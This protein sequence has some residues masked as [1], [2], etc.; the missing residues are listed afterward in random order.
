MATFGSDWEDTSEK[1]YEG[2]INYAHS[3]SEAD[4]DSFGEEYKGIMGGTFSGGKRAL[5]KAI[6]RDLENNFTSNL[7]RKKLL[8]LQE[9]M[10]NKY[11]LGGGLEPA[12]I[13]QHVSNWSEIPSSW[14]KLGAFK[15]IAFTSDPYDKNL[16]KLL[17]PFASDDDLRPAMTGM[18]F[19]EAGITC[20]DAHK[21]VVLPYPN[22]EYKGIYCTFKRCSKL[23]SGD[24]KIDKSGKLIEKL[25]K[26]T[27][28]AKY[29]KYEAVIPIC[30]A[31]KQNHDKINLRKLLTYI[32]VAENF[33]NVT[34]HQIN[35]K[36]KG[37][38]I[39]F[40]STFLKT[41]CEAMLYLGYEDVWFHTST[42]DR[43]VVVTPSETYKLGVEV[44]MLC[45][46]VHTDSKVYSD[47]PGAE[48]MD[49]EKEISV[50]FDFSDNEI[51]NADKT[52]ADFYK[53][54]KVITIQPEQIRFLKSAIDKN[55][56]IPILDH[57]GV[58]S[59]NAIGADFENYAI[60]KESGL[61]DGEYD[62]VEGE[63]VWHSGANDIN[64]FPKVYTAKEELGKVYAPEFEKVYE[65]AIKF[66]IKDDFAPEFGGIHLYTK[67][68][69]LVMES[70]DA[71]IAY[72]NIIKGFE[73]KKNLILCCQLNA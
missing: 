6:E 3:E 9:K 43:A 67:D 64:E 1:D 18:Y 54:E 5:E 62:I 31:K 13:T 48:D 50:Y 34:T 2:I 44:L 60:I 23:V 39:G 33:A 22:L 19:D 47:T 41:I 46:P 58:I 59:G 17:E 63:L 56:A 32:N 49:W 8:K 12:Q 28:D 37:G 4:E 65:D 36:Y 52:V 38:L 71:I 57:V 14:K 45:M 11:K 68:K 7:E 21:L 26:E 27:R 69:Q 29:P 20:T 53:D 51:H 66:I 10:E 24:F 70:C 55:I 61:K 35:F 40:N 15:P 42:P 16:L 30:D 25:D 72:R 73:F